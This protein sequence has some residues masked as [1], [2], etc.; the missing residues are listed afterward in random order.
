ML[1]AFEAGSPDVL[2]V[3]DQSWDASSEASPL[4]SE[5]SAAA[6]PIL[7]ILRTPPAGVDGFA[8]DD[9]VTRATLSAELPSR[10]S[11]SFYNA[12]PRPR[13]DAGTAVAALADERFFRLVVHDLRT[14]LNVI[15]LSLS[16][17]KQ[18]VPRG[19]AGTWTKI[20]DS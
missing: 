16:M 4:L 11:H 12:E 3:T 14:P 19:D 6:V 13:R 2:I 18:A 5:A 10:R 15:S 20:Y 1:R 7:A 8:C 17:I 9:W